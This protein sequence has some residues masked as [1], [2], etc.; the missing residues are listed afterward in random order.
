MAIKPIKRDV[1]DSC[2]KELNTKQLAALLAAKLPVAALAPAH[3]PSSYRPKQD[4]STV[5]Q[6]SMANDKELDNS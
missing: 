5:V 4:E 3:H 1:D 6:L 2:E